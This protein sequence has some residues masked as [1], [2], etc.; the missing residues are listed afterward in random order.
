MKK[1]WMIIEKDIMRE[2]FSL[3]E[4]ITFGI[5]APSMFV[6]LLVLWSMLQTWAAQ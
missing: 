6:L 3:M 2:G 5:I 1:F 4:I